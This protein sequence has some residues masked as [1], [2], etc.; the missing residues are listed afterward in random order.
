MND[1]L[2]GSSYYNPILYKDKWKIYIDPD[3][4]PP[5]AYAYVHVDYDGA[6][7]AIDHRYGFAFTIEEAKAKIDEYEANR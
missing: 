5:N 2:P 3:T 7:D 6:T 4:W 1:R